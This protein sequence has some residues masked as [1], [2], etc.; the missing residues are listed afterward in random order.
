METG[1]Q[2]NC[3]HLALDSVGCT[4]KEKQL[5]Q[6]NKSVVTGSWTF[7]KLLIVLEGDGTEIPDE[8]F[9]DIIDRGGEETAKTDPNM[10]V[11][12]TFGSKS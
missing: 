3:R 7:W 12:D 4:P 8:T 10:S 11:T 5:N 6:K 2:I 9:N 1:K